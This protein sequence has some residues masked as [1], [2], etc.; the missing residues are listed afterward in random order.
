MILSAH[1]RS[2]LNIFEK[3]ILQLLLEEDRIIAFPTD[4]VYGLGVNAYS[5]RAVQA[6]YD[7][8]KRNEGKAFVLLID[9]PEKARPYIAD[10]ELLEKPLLKKHWPGPLTCI[11]ETKPNIPIYYAKSPIN[12]LGIRIPMHKLLLDLLA[13]LPF[14]LASTSANMSEQEPLN[15]AQSIE[16]VFNSKEGDQRLACII[17]QGTIIGSPSTVVELSSSSLK[18]L[19]QGSLNIDHATFL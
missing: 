19:R 4:T 11:F 18:V 16:T 9:T 5:S 12:T 17:D 6:M 8:K 13:F 14:P 7:L 15:D 10:E 2:N 1:H 3:K